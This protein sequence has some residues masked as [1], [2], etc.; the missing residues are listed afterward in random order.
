[1]SAIKAFE[2][3]R[4]R[5]LREEFYQRSLN[6]HHHKRAK[7]RAYEIAARQAVATLPTGSQRPLNF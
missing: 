3:A 1:V 4:L 5:V 7:E 2:L 6:S